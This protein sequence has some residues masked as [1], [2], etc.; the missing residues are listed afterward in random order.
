[1]RTLSAVALLC[2]GSAFAAD[3][4]PESVAKLIDQL[5]SPDYQAREAASR[6]LDALGGPALPALKRAAASSGDAEAARRAAELAVRIARRAD[7][8]RALA[9][10]LVELDFEDAPLATVLDALRKQGGGRLAFEPAGAPGAKLTVKTGGKVPYWDAVA[11]V[12]AA[13]GLEVAPAAAPV[14][15]ASAARGREAQLLADQQAAIV[16]ALAAQQRLRAAQAAAAK[17]AIP[18]NKKAEDL[19]QQKAQIEQ[20]LAQLA[21]LQAMQARQAAL[22]RTARSASA[23]PPPNPGVVSLRPKSE[24]PNPSCVSGAVR[25]EAV[26]LPA[27]ALATVP[28][29]TVPVVLHASPEPR[30][31]WERVESVRVTRA[32]DD[33]DRE[34][35]AAMDEA[36][37]PTRVF[38]VQG[39]AV[40]FGGNGMV[41]LL[42]SREPNLS[43]G[44]APTATQALVRLKA[45]GAPTS[46]QTLE[47]VVRGVIR[48]GP[49][50][51][52]AAA[53]LDKK[54]TVSALGV[55]G[56][57]LAVTVAE[58]PEGD[59]FEVE[60]T[61][62]YDPAEVQVSGQP[63]YEERVLNQGRGRVVVR[64]QIQAAVRLPALGTVPGEANAFGLTV[65]DADGKP[66]TLTAVSSRRTHDRTGEEVTDR[67]KLL[68]RPSGEGQGGPARVSFAGTRTKV[69]EVP[70][71]LT[72]VP[73]A[74]GTAEV[75]DESKK[76]AGR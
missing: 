44:F 73:V 65:T 30:L 5:G 13:A 42:P 8:D 64:G 60:A 66:F 54:P 38:P 52:A 4:S 39:G 50:E 70:F 63:D 62:R 10:T 24:R 16:A 72:D 46:L 9:P 75:P 3:P 33:A 26:S 76:P 7:N 61:L 45:S 57:A 25:V 67:V 6:E 14:Q 17:N 15:T 12:C 55:N 18:G 53:G 37:L 2:L 31:K 68:A 43:P 20:A 41:N 36:T 56:V 21:Q 34:L 48:T 11:R 29:D 49:E 47:G 19:Q 58:R 35:A 40:V 28:R 71:K 27:A 32:I 74:V 59:A 22:D 23:S 1:M 51:L 69:V